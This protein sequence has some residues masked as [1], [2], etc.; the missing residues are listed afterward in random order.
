MDKDQSFV[1]R[2]IIIK[3]SSLFIKGL[4]RTICR[5]NDEVT[6]YKTI[7]FLTNEEAK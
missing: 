6:S 5:Q 1:T 2:Y 3:H 4:K 7:F